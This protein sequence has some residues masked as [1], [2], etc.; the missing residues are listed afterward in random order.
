[1]INGGLTF[2]LDAILAYTPG[3]SGS[4]QP[5]LTKF[6]E[7]LLIDNQNERH[8]SKALI[9]T[10]TPGHNSGNFIVNLVKKWTTRVF[11]CIV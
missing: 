1:M 8:V 11:V 4:A 2:A 6:S 3:K 5:V 7:M 9:L 10:I